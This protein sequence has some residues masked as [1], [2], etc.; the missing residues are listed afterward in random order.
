MTFNS[1]AKPMILTLLVTG[2]LTVAV[3]NLEEVRS[4]A[5][6]VSGVSTVN[7]KAVGKATKVTRQAKLGGGDYGVSN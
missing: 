2:V 4:G 5:G 3:G 7:L 6:V 1:V